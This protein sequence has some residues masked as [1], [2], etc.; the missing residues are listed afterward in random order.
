MLTNQLNSAL[1]FILVLTLSS[2]AQLSLFQDAKTA[3]K[4]NIT[5]GGHLSGYGVTGEENGSFDQIILPSIVVHGGYGVTERLDLQLSASMA[6][7]LLFAPKYQIL[8]NRTSKWA[9]AVNP[10]G[11]VHFGDF[12]D[13]NIG[14]F[15][16]HLSSIGSY[17]PS[18]KMSIFVEPRYIVQYQNRRDVD[19][20][21]GTN[22]GIQLKISEMADFSIGSSLFR[23]N[24]SNQLLFQL[25]L[26][27]RLKLN[28]E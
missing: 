18:D 23:V 2:C 21:Y 28:T 1:C 11:E 8:G 24:D 17:H 5:V 13:R 3:G 4:G 10:G 9:M 26:G 20:F 14:V 12:D 25:G 19:I 27:L 7:S 6:G 16:M 15:R 22:A